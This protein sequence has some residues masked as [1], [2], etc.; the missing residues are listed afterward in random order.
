MSGLAA[1]LAGRVPPGVYRWH[2]AFDVAD[3]ADTVGRAGTRFAHLDG[4]TVGGKAEVLAA[5][6]ER[7]G[8]PETYGRN[9]DALEDCL[10]D[11]GRDGTATVLLWDGW[12]TLAHDD[13][14]TF[15]VLLDILRT[16]AAATG[17][18][19]LTVLLRG[20]GPPVEGL[21]DLV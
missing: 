6:G 2:A 18:A 15:A 20:E 3:V 8:F 21:A 10:R 11:L 16:R 5:L 1:V 13:P 19:G 9:L 17:R 12:G 7:L 4:W 14:R